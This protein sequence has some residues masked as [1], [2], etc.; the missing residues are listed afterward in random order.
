M[1][2]FLVQ[3]YTIYLQ[4]DSITDLWQRGLILLNTK[5]PTTK[6]IWA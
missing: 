5:T 2:T 4:F 6:E 1:Y 3:D